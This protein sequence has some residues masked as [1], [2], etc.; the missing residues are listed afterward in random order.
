MNR[1]SYLPDY[2]PFH[3]FLS[4][5]AGVGKSFMKI[6]CESMDEHPAVVVSASTGKAT[7]NVNGTILRSAFGLPLR[8]GIT[9]TQLAW[10]KKDNFQKKCVNLKALL[11]DEIP[12]TLKLTFNDF[13]VNT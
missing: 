12:K 2:N 13:N 4:S 8:E 5:D 10:N 6:H 1:R 3:I 11:G 9:F 7:I